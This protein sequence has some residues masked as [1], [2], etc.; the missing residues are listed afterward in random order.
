MQGAVLLLRRDAFDAVGGFD[1][2]FFMYGEDADLCE[3]LRSAGW[4]VELYEAAEFVHVGGGS[5]GTRRERM[6]RE[7]LRSWL[8]LIA[9]RDG[10]ARARRA[11]RWLIRALRIKAVRDPAARATAD[12]LTSR[13][14]DDLL[15]GPHE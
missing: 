4:R 11:R 2:D 6:D 3:R 15:G 13:P 10:L 5:T 9:K 8:R 14:L 7:L 1:E 12:W